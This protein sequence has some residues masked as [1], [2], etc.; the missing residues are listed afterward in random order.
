M[1]HSIHLQ[2]GLVPIVLARSLHHARRVAGVSP[3]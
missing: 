1:T 2:I 3:R